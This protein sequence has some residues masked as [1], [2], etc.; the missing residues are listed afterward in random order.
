VRGGRVVTLSL[1]EAVSQAIAEVTE[2]GGDVFVCR[3]ER[4]GC[5]G[6]PLA[7]TGSCDGCYVIGWGSNRTLD[8]HLRAIER[9]D[10]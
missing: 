1:R 3:G 4:I 10:A 6:L 8:E 9:G 2:T 5:G 7:M